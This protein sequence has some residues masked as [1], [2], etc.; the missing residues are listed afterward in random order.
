MTMI[1]R[2][3]TITAIHHRNQASQEN[4]LAMIGNPANQ[5]FQTIAINQ[6]NQ[7]NQENQG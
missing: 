5:E 6:G 1:L 4:R 7:A 2:I 3:K